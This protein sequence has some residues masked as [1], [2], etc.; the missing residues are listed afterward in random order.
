[1]LISAT[2]S[3]NQWIDNRFYW[4]LINEVRSQRN[5]DMHNSEQVKR[6]SREVMTTMLAMLVPAGNA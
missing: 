5:I 3:H 4:A 2:C 6:A 1:M